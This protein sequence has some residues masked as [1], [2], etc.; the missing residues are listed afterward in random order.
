LTLGVLLAALFALGGIRDA[1]SS[2]SRWPAEKHARDV[3]SE[4]DGRLVGGVKYV[5][6]V[7]GQ[8]FFFDGQDDAVSIPDVEAL[9]LTQSLTISGWVRVDGYPPA[10]QDYGFV[11]FRGDDRPGL[12]PYFLGVRTDGNLVFGITSEREDAHLRAP[13]P[14]GKFIQVTASLDD[15]TGLMR[16]MFDGRVVAQAVTTV[17]PF[18]DLATDAHPGIGIGNHASQPDSQYNMPFHGVLD[19]ISISS[20]TTLAPSALS[21]QR[22]GKGGYVGTVTLGTPAPTGGARVALGASDQEVTVPAS[23][24]I[25]PDTTTATFAVAAADAPKG[26][27]ITAVYNGFAKSTK[28]SDAVK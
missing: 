1:A 17:R 14:L 19:E 5:P 12:D 9:R 24:T 21:L 20:E 2:V 28:L 25:A 8:G 11:L 16:L 26:A 10:G 22:D 27:A 23:V 18:H 7:V 3:V 15:H 4:H 6:A 13:I